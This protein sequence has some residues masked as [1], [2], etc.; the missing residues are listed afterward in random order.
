MRC[1]MRAMPRHTGVLIGIKLYICKLSMRQHVYT[2]MRTH[3]TRTYIASTERQLRDTILL[4]A[5]RELALRI[6]ELHRLLCR[7]LE[8]AKRSERERCIRTCLL[9][10]SM[11]I[12][13]KEKSAT[14][15]C[16][17]SD[18]FIDDHRYH[19]SMNWCVNCLSK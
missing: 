9:K 1:E 7:G 15:A 4:G 2:C 18:D 10:M 12:E 16:S 17:S 6:M 19:R 8:G 11:N 3:D 5:E 13:D 14:A